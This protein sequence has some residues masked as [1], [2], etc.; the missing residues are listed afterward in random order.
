MLP[1]DDGQRE[2]QAPALPENRDQEVSPT[3][4]V[5]GA[6]HRDVERFMKHPHLMIPSRSRTRR[7][8]SNVALILPFENGI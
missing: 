1:L 8:S 6:C 4:N 5:A 2:G 7:T 3:G